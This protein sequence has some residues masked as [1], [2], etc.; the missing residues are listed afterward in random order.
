MIYGVGTDILDIQKIKPLDDNYTDP[1]F[2]KTFSAL[3]RDLAAA[4][5]DPDIYY[6][7]RF[8]AKEAVFKSL[9]LDGNRVRLNEIE[10]I[11]NSLGAPEVQLRG[12]L[13]QIAEQK[14]I[15][16]INLSL[17]WDG[18]YA[19]AFAISEINSTPT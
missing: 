19:L 10:I 13:K 17:S 9:R 16:K 3:E 14:Q 12:N 6:A 7:T 8:A 4:R 18:Q 5:P 1:F 2:L 11:S 15:I